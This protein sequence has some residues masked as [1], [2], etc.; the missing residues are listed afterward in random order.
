[1][2]FGIQALVHNG[3]FALWSRGNH[4][5]AAACG[6]VPV[7]IGEVNGVVCSDSQVV[8]LVE[9]R[10]GPI[11]RQRFEKFTCLKIDAINRVIYVGSL[12]R[13][14]LELRRGQLEVPGDRGRVA[15]QVEED[16]DGERSTGKTA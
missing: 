12:D 3:G 10:A 5:D 11:S 16:V 13:G 1:M 4:K 2:P 8:W 7:G 9:L 14:Q 6:R 15:I